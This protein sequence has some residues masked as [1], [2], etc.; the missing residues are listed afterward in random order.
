[1][2]AGGGEPAVPDGRQGGVAEAMGRVGG[3]R[4]PPRSRSASIPPRAR[5]LGT[6]P[7]PGRGKRGGLLPVRL[8]GRARRPGGRDVEAMQEKGDRLCRASS[9]GPGSFSHFRFFPPELR[10]LRAPEAKRS[11]DARRVLVRLPCPPGTVAHAV[12]APPCHAPFPPRHLVPAPA[13]H[14]RGRRNAFTGPALPCKLFASSS[15]LLLILITILIFSA[16]MRVLHPCKGW[17][18]FL[19][20]GSRNPPPACLVFLVPG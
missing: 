7:M 10:L 14:P 1:M 2:D 3:T 4:S 16:G 9:E 17:I 13:P 8:P 5:S 19:L 15:L 11:L 20:E 12:L 6:C 18:F